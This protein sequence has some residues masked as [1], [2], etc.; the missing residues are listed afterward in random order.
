MPGS[1]QGI[2]TLTTDGINFLTEE[3]DIDAELSKY[4][5]KVFGP[6]NLKEGAKAQWKGGW[7][8]W[9]ATANFSGHP[10]MGR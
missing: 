8:N 10:R 3:K 4:W 7:T 9:E 5:A 6:P 1:R 2:H